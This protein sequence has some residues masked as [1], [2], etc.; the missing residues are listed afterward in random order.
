[1]QG[2]FDAGIR[3]LVS[4]RRGLLADLATAIADA[5]AN[6][7]AISMEKPDGAGVIAMF[8]GVQVRDRRHLAA[9]M[10]N[11]HRIKDVRKVQRART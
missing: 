10:R 8:F 3:L 4:D 1:V 7:D 9:V 6:I 2:D 5:Q 11:V